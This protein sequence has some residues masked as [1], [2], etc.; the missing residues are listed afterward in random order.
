MALAE[1]QRKFII[2]NL[3]FLRLALVHQFALYFKF[4]VQ[5]RQKKGWPIEQDLMSIMS[6]IGPQPSKPREGCS[7]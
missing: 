7:C 3:N 1:F 2:T 6:L 4:G 5:F